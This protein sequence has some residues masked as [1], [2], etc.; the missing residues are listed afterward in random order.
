[1]TRVSFYIL[2]DDSNRSRSLFICRLA[3]KAY[4]S[5]ANIYIHT[6]SAEQSSDLDT[7]LWTFNRVS[8]IP[9]ART[10]QDEEQHGESV[11]LGH[12]QAPESSHDILINLSPQVPLFFSRFERVMEVINQ[13]ES[14]KEDGRERYRFYKERGYELESHT[15]K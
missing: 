7:L 9:H 5:G 8:F 15:I 14:T 2:N 1:M 6:A 11:L 4:R 10:D 3:Q 12:Q 13:D